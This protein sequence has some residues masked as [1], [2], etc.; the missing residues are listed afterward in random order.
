MVQTLTETLP[1]T[2]DQVRRVRRIV[3]VALGDAHPCLDD[4]VLL[5]SETAT[6]AITHSDS[7][8]E[9]GKLTLRVECTGTWARVSVRDDGSFRLPCWCR[10]GRTATNG[11]GTELLDNLATRWG[12]LREGV[13]STVWFELEHCASSSQTPEWPGQPT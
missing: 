11:R 9:G 13:G 6:N 10:A 4:A 5:S 1:G 3:G 2:P 8:M 7:G 12:V